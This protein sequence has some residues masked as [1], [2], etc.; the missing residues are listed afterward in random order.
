M[1]APAG[2]Y[3]HTSCCRDPSRGAGVGQL[4]MAT[5]LTY[6]VLMCVC[7]GAGGNPT[8]R[9]TKCESYTLWLQQPSR[10]ADSITA[11]LA[12]QLETA[13][14]QVQQYADM[15]EAA[16]LQADEATQQAA[17]QVRVL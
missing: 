5:V 15:A 12:G 14:E 11:Q 6:Q 4:C 1:H 17:Q 16:T 9:T 3:K 10:P 13:K 7:A 8:M 2:A